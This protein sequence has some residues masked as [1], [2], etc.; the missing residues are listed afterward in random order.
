MRTRNFLL[1]RPGFS[2]ILQILDHAV[3][4]IRIT[5]YM[6]VLP[7]SRKSEYQKE[8]VKYVLPVRNAVPSLSARADGRI[9]L[10]DS[11]A[12]TVNYIYAKI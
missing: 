9:I 2:V 6:Y 12:F 3:C 7:V 1:W 4:R 5:T 10:K 8:K 11:Y